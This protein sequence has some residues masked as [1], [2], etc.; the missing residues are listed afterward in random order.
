[1]CVYTVKVFL[2]IPFQLHQCTCFKH[3]FDS[4]NVLKNRKAQKCGRIKLVNQIP[5]RLVI[6]KWNFI[7]QMWVMMWTLS[8]RSTLKKT[9]D[10]CMDNPQKWKSKNI[11]TGH[12]CMSEVKACNL[13]IYHF[14]LRVITLEPYSKFKP[15]KKHEKLWNI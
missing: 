10:M 2:R 12:R 14:Q 4:P 11:S 5:L 13:Q 9:F 8:R 6:I 1:M 15:V 7:E 3:N